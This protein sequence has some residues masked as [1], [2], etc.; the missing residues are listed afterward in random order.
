MAQGR[1]VFKCIRIT[2]MAQGKVGTVPTDCVNT[3]GHRLRP[4]D[5]PTPKCH[6]GVSKFWCK[7]CGGRGYC[8]HGRNRYRCKECPE[9]KSL[10]EHRV[11]KYRCPR[12]GTG[13]CQH[14]RRKD[15]CTEC[16]G[17][18]ICIHGRRRTRCQNCGG[19][20]L[21]THGRRKDKPC[22]Q[23]SEEAQQPAVVEGGE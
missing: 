22:H 4:A 17:S 23:C 13:Q 15:S 7:P 20:S 3:R 6:H 8:Q 16:G 19:G 21:C 14:G 12:C 11:D 1:G 2:C 10:C 18:A 9:A 5:M